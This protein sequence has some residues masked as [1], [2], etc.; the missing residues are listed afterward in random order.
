MGHLTRAAEELHTSQSAVSAQIRQL[1][2]QLDEDL[3]LREDAG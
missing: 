1:E 2:K 3:F